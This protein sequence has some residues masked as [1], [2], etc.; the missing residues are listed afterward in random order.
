MP[1][2]SVEVKVRGDVQGVGFRWFVERTALGL[3]LTGWVANA[4]DGSVSVVA[5]GP[6]EAID[7]LLER[8]REGPPGA[9]VRAVTAGEVSPSGRFDR[10]EIRSGWH[11]G[12]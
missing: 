2:R 9:H 10:F 8:L 7:A 3:G 5:E 6:S 11:R 1:E 4:D 12:D